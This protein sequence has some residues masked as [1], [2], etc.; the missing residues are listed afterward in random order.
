MSYMTEYQSYSNKIR[1][2][3]STIYKNQIRV[4]KI[5]VQI[6]SLEI[7]NKHINKKLGKSQ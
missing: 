4:K 1:G 3:E 7:I 5:Y 2:I 6:N